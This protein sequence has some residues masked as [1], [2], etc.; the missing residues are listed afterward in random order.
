MKKLIILFS[1]L[2]IANLASADSD[3]DCQKL[4]VNIGYEDGAKSLEKKLESQ[5]KLKNLCR[6]Y[7]FSPPKQNTDFQKCE[8]SDEIIAIYKESF[9]QGVRDSIEPCRNSLERQ[10]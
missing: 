4:A 1:A 5:L 10:N 2:C 7:L 8:K 9:L 6:A 3:I